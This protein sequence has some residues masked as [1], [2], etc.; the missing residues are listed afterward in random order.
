MGILMLGEA[1]LAWVTQALHR[2]V[3]GPEKVTLGKPER[4]RGWRN[5]SIEL[6]T[7]SGTSIIFSQKSLFYTA[8][9]N[10]YMKNFSEE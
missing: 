6:D 8:R 2:P 7:C 4:R 5:F 10:L 3:Q 9:C 1:A